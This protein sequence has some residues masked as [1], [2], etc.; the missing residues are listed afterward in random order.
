MPTDAGTLVA[1]TDAGLLLETR[2]HSGL[3][4]WKP[5]AA[6][7]ALPYAPLPEDGFDVT[8][9]LIAYGTGCSWHVTAQN[10]GYKACTVLR[11]LNLVTGKL[12]SFPEPLG[13]AGWV[14]N[15]FDL[16]SAIAP[17]NQMI[18]AYAVARPQRKG[19]ARL[20]AVR[21]TG[22]SDR[23][24]EVPSSVAPLFARTAWSAAGSWLLYQGSRT[25][26]WAYQVT[27][28]K[29]HASSTPCCQY[30]AMAAVANRSG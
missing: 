10:T 26:L 21:I 28:G 9:R 29:V 15:G 20:Y 23:P 3:A 12:V 19:D 11:V 27:T 4:L 6:A 17:D 8:A 13:T 25:H 7:M 2:G 18:A 5:G 14:P 1:G 24:T 16:V 22:T 30:T